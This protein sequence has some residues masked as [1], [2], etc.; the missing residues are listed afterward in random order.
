MLLSQR[1]SESTNSHGETTET[2][3]LA[4][5]D[6]SVVL[7][8]ASQTDKFMP[9]TAGDSWAKQYTFCGRQLVELIQK[10]GQRA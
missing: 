4:V 1:W 6:G 3:R 2:A 7:T 5:A 9:G 8:V 10:Y